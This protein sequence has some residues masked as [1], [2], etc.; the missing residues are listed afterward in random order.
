MTGGRNS[1]RERQRRKERHKKS[2]DCNGWT[3]LAEKGLVKLFVQSLDALQGKAGVLDDF[4]H[5]FIIVGRYCSIATGVTRLGGNHPYKRF[6]MSN[7]TYL[8]SRKLIHTLGK[9]LSNP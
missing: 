5:G 2:Q 7:I 6:M 1:G 9:S 4:I 3:V 8:T